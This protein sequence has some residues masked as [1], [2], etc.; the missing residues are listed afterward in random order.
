[1]Q[2]ARWSY[3]RLLRRTEVGEDVVRHDKGW[4]VEA[5]VVDENPQRRVR[6]ELRLDSLDEEC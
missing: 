4:E 6:L 5:T 3:H 1:M 2:G